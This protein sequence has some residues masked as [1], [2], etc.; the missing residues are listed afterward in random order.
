MDRDVDQRLSELEIEL[1]REHL[2]G[3]FD[4]RDPDNPEPSANRSAAYRH[5][6]AVA[7]AEL[8][9]RPRLAVLSRLAAG[10]IATDERVKV[11]TGQ[12]Y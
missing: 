5:S 8:A 9:N 6:F 1:D 2:D 11:I 4:G 3:Y 7:R 10:Q 12:R